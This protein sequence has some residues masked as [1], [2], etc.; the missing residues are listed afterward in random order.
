MLIFWNLRN[1]TQRRVPENS[2]AITKRHNGLLG[3]DACETGRNLGGV[4]KGSSSCWR[5][6]VCSAAGSKGEGITIFRKIG[7]YLRTDTAEHPRR[8]EPSSHEPFWITFLKVGKMPVHFQAPSKIEKSDYYLRQV[9]PSFCPH[10]A[11]RWI[12]MKFGIWEFFDNLSK[13]FKINKNPTRITGTL[14][15]YFFT[16]LTIS[17]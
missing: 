7:S 9:C 14:H 8:L 13:N 4:A 6:A 17:L 10:K 11:T 3:H 15:E 1:S 5:Q 16:F 12:L 2:S